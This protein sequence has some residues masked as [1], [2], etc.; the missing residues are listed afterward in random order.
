[1]AGLLGRALNDSN[2]PFIFLPELRTR[3]KWSSDKLE[4]KLP[5]RE[6]EP[7]E[8]KLQNFY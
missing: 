3:K 1:M 4:L 6:P 2:F 5:R 8:P 7:L